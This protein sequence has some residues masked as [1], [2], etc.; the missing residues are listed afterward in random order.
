MEEEITFIRTQSKISAGRGESYRNNMDCQGP[1][2]C[3]QRALYL[4]SRELQ[5][6]DHCEDRGNYKSVCASS[7][8]NE[9]FGHSDEVG[10]D[11]TLKGPDYQAMEF[12]L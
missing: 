2:Q 8:Q 6:L 9:E 10:D 4:F 3:L 7:G 1:F 11:V 5:S 12:S